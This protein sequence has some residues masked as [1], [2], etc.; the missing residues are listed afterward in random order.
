MKTLLITI[1]YQHN[2]DKYWWDSS[3]KKQKVVFDPEEQTIHELI[4]ELC[5][6]EGMELTYKGKPR[7][8]TYFDTED[9][10]RK[11]AGYIYRGKTIIDSRDIDIKPVMS[12][13][14]VWATIEEVIEY[15]LESV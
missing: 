6:D 9:G 4:K 15:E 14:D 13:W 8:N 1:N 3:V 12:Y 2:P 11:Q 5:G 7:D 10:G